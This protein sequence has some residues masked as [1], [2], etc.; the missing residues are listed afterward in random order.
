MLLDEYY[1]NT[2]NNKMILFGFLAMAMLLWTLNVSFQLKQL[3]ANTQSL[4]E[5]IENAASSCGQS[6]N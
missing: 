2:N 1:V 5:E 3:E 4:Q 6:L